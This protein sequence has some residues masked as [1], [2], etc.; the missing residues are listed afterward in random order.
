MLSG[1]GI[2]HWDQR[3]SYACI[4]DVSIF[5][6][7]ELTVLLKYLLV[8]QMKIELLGLFLLLHDTRD[9]IERHV[10]KVSSNSNDFD[11]AWIDEQRWE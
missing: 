11:D 6:L 2:Y 4:C 3:Q 7:S 10:R 5:T 1:F 9:L 8:G